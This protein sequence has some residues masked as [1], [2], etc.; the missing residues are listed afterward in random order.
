MLLYWCMTAFV[1]S[2][3]EMA[4][5]ILGTYSNVFIWKSETSSGTSSDASDAR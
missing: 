4:D 2:G 3:K 1:N 5:Q